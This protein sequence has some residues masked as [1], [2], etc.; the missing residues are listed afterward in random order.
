MREFDVVIV[1]AGIIGLAHAYAFAKRGKKVAVFEKSPRP[2]GASIRNFGMVWTIGQPPGQ[3]IDIATTSNRLWREFLTDSK[4]W[5]HESG[6]LHLAYHDDELEV[7]EEFY[8]MSEGL[9]YACELKTKTEVES[10]SSV[11]R[12]EGLR[13]GLMGTTELSV[14]PRLTLSVLPGYLQEKFG[15]EFFFETAVTHVEVNTVGNRYFQ[16]RSEQTVICNGDDFE[17]LFPE[18]YQGS[19]LGRCKLQMMRARFVMEGTKIGPHL[20]AGLTLLHYKN[21]SICKGLAALRQRYERDWPAQIEHGIHLLVSQHEH[22]EITVGDTH[23][24]GMGPA[25]F[26]RADLDE[27]VLDYLDTFLPRELFTITERWMGVYATYD[28]APFF[29]KSISAS[30]HTVTGVG[31]AGMTLSFGL[32]E[33]TAAKFD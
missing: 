21:F 30:V 29:E 8:A 31:G 2:L 16:V 23:E 11:V 13:G 5:H 24:Y 22:G 9:G 12:R 26:L 7:F 25:P 32:G 18:I 20:C 10:L 1:G 4:T 27:L 3:M 28:A 33:H 6:A 14:D 17:T 15:V 19:G